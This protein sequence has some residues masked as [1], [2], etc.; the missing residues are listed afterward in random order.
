LINLAWIPD[1][2]KS[3]EIGTFLCSPLSL[4]YSSLC[5]YYSVMAKLIFILFMFLIAMFTV[6][7]D[8]MSSIVTVLLLNSCIYSYSV[9][10]KVPRVDDLHY[11]GLVL[12]Y[13]AYLRVLPDVPGRVV[14]CEGDYYSF[15]ESSVVHPLCIDYVECGRVGGDGCVLKAS[16]V[17]APYVWIMI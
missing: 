4:Y 14:D 9:Y 8:Y 5:V 3:V 11:V 1:V 2:V 15:V 13:I 6:Y 17:N 7:F 12:R 16:L 10:P